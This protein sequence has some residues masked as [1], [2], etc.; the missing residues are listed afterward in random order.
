MRPV[1]LG[2]V[3]INVGSGKATRFADFAYLEGE[4][5]L[6]GQVLAVDGTREVIGKVLL[7]FRAERERV[8][9][10][11]SAVLTQEGRFAVKDVRD[12]AKKFEAKRVAA[13]YLGQ[14]GL[15]PCDAKQEIRF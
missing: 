14:P 2:G 5:Q 9:T 6:R 13:H 3:Q 7:N 8:G 4:N 15:A 12:W 11:V 1:L 10:S